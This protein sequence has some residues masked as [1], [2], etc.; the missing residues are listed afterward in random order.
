MR[1]T[2]GIDFGTTNTRVVLYR[3]GRFRNVIDR[4]GG[5]RM[6]PTCIAYDRRNGEF[7]AFGEKA[8]QISDRNVVVV[9]DLKW[10]FDEP[11]MRIGAGVLTFGQMVEDFFRALAK[12]TASYFADGQIDRLPSAALTTPVKY[13]WKARQEVVK[14]AERAGFKVEG[15]FYEPVAAAYC[16]MDEMGTGVGMYSERVLAFDWGGGTLDSALVQVRFEGGNAYLSVKGPLAGVQKGG[17][18]LDTRI[19]MDAL[20]AAVRDEVEFKL[21]WEGSNVALLNAAEKVKM[22]LSDKEEASLSPHLGAGRTVDIR[23]TRREF[24]ERYLGELL[25]DVEKVLANYPERSIWVVAVGGT[26][27]IPGVKRFLQRRYGH[28]KVMFRLGEGKLLKGDTGDATARGAA[29]ML[30]NSAGIRLGCDVGVRAVDLGSGERRKEIFVPL[31]QFGEKVSLAGHSNP[32][33][34]IRLLVTDADC[35]HATIVVAK[36]KPEDL[37][38]GEIMDVMLLPLGSLPGLW[39]NVEAKFERHLVLEVSAATVD[40]GHRGE[41]RTRCCDVPFEFVLPRRDKNAD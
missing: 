13:P 5:T 38:T 3:D 41:V 27:N 4:V 19:A 26:C 29:L 1:E 6:I 11:P 18:F 40:G 2:L 15:V 30:A 8:R 34:K 24:E 37:G 7:L 36:R 31:I 21:L 28:D 25:D 10:R 9:R 20:R 14:A 35:G 39:I 22:D 23:L 33:G 12:L 16:F 17:T 32:H